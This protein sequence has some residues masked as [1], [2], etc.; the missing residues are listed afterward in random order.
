M[1]SSVW[2]WGSLGSGSLGEQ[3]LGRPE[4]PEVP[5]GTQLPPLLS[6]CLG[7]KF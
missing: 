5:E 3:H 6:P 1:L 2:G 4:V 7:G